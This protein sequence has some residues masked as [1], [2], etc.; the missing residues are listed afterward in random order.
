[1]RAERFD[2]RSCAFQPARRPERLDEAR[3]I[4]ESAADA[5]RYAELRRNTAH[6]HL[7]RNRISH[8]RTRRDTGVHLCHPGIDQSRPVSG[9]LAGNSTILTLIG[10]AGFGNSGATGR[11]PSAHGVVI[12]PAPVM[13]KVR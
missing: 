12:C 4:Y 3:E 9:T 2:A 8:R 5:N 6:G 10:A 11:M 7:Q 13:K 1:M